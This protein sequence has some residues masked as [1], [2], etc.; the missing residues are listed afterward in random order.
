M[1]GVPGITSLRVPDTRPGR[2]TAGW[3]WRRSTDSRIRAATIAAFCSESLAIRFLRTVRP[4]IA[5]RD[6]TTFIAEA[7]FHRDCPMRRAISQL[8]RGSPRGARPGPR[9]RREFHQAATPPTRHKPQ[10]PRPRGTTWISCF[11][12]TMHPVLTCIHVRTRPS[13]G[14]PW[15]NTISPVH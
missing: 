12:S 7:W 9:Y 4:E 13:P 6:Q 2:P 5:L 10:S 3:V 1:Y 14:P 8:A 11:A 15:G